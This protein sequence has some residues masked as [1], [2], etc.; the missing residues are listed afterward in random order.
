MPESKPTNKDYNL[1]FPT[2]LRFLLEEKGK[3]SQSQLADYIGVT[4]QAISAYS[5]GNSV[6]DI[7]KSQKMAELDVYK[8]QVLHRPT[9]SYGGSKS[10]EKKTPIVLTMR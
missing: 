1:P 8:R 10:R 5:L 9:K 4:R 3:G 6:P 2:R 7:Y